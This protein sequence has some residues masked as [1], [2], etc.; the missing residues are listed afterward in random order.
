MKNV[1]NEVQKGLKKL[2]DKNLEGHAL[3]RFNNLCGLVTGILISGSS[4]LS[5]IGTGFPLDINAASKEMKAKRFL[6]NKW[7]DTELHYLPF[8]TTFLCACILHGENLKGLYLVIDGSQIGKHNA[9]LMVSIVWKKRG[10][11]ICWLV[12][13]GSKGHFKEKDHVAIL[14]IAADILKPLLGDKS[15]PIMLLGDGEFDGIEVQ[16]FCEKAGWTYALRT[17]NSTILYENGEAFKAANISP[18]ENTNYFFIPNVLFTHKKYGT[19]QFLCYHD[20]KKYD[21]PI[22]LVSNINDI[23]AIIYAYNLRY[24]IEC[25]FKD[26]K[27]SSFNIHQTRLKD[28]DEVNRLLIVACLAFILLLILG[29]ENDNIKMRKKVQRVRQDRKVLSFFTFA[30]RLF[31]YLKDHLLPIKFYFQNSKNST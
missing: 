29:L 25:L 28:K 31:N 26:I 19:I 12:K 6:A 7:I 5:K 30:Y 24:S 3:R 22:F 9:T 1:Y 11:P 14:K 16:K 18:N 13:S 10:I 21:N 4:S 23:K 8:L 20:T 27:S 2:S 17:A 15:L